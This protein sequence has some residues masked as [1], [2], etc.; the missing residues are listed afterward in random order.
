MWLLVSLIASTLSPGLA[1]EP[2]IQTY[3]ESYLSYPYDPLTC[4]YGNLTPNEVDETAFGFDL[5]KIPLDNID[6]VNIAFLAPN[7]YT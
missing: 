4:Y 3:W 5:T 6:K 2:F 1:A 7:P